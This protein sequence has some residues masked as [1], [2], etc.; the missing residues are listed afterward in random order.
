MSTPPSTAKILKTNE[1]ARELGLQ[2][3]QFR[4]LAI[5]AGVEPKKYRRNDLWSEA[6]VE[7]LR[8]LLAA[9]E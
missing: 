9:D 1:A 2:P 8:A 5:K 6:D 7:Q 3:E 4:R